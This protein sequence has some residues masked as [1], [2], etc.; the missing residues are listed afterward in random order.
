MLVIRLVCIKLCILTYVKVVYVLRGFTNLVQLF[1]RRNP[2]AP[3]NNRSSENARLKNR[4]NKLVSLKSDQVLPL[5]I[6]SDRFL[7]SALSRD[8]FL[9]HAVL[10]LDRFDSLEG[11]NP[12]IW[13]NLHWKP[14]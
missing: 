8:R 9:K 12:F 13:T 3:I 1:Y 10:R 14:P 11:S 2:I 7:K 6:A 4:S 5:Y